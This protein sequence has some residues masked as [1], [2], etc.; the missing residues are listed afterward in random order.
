[1]K[2]IPLSP[3]WRR[4]MAGEHKKWIL[5]VAAATAVMALLAPTFMAGADEHHR[6][7]E[8]QWWRHGDIRRFKE[9]DLHRWRGGHWVHARHGGRFGWWWVVGGGW[10][11][12][13]SPI[14]P[15][16]NPYVPPVVVTPAPPPPQAAPQ[17]WYYCNSARGY[18]PY[19]TSCP[20][21][22]MQVVPQS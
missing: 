11:F 19:V 6:D 2:S 18:Y 15:Y 13:P 4:V 9:A 20:E 1:M 7:R 14:Y 8:G 16:P 12:Y 3:E 22:W 17:Y 10:Y 5:R 21:G